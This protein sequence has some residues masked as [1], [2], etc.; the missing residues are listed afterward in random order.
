M[1]KR[2]Q[3]LERMV[4]EWREESKEREEEYREKVE[5]REFWERQAL[6]NL[7]SSQTF[8]KT[9]SALIFTPALLITGY[10]V[11]LAKGTWD[12]VIHLLPFLSA[13]AMEVLS[14]LFFWRG[15]KIDLNAGREE[16][17]FQRESMKQKERGFLKLIV[18]ISLPSILI[19]LVGGFWMDG[20]L[21]AATA[22]RFALTVLFFASYFLLR[23]EWG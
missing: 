7:K 8:N 11:I 17:S 9:I 3:Y 21:S 4:E 2:S 20:T 14:L 10:G 12:T 22:I 16:L 15:G 1:V 6:I 19:C 13:L 5:E 23:A 18:P